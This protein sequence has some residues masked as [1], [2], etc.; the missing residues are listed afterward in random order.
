MNEGDIMDRFKG[1]RASI[2][3]FLEK[4]S[5]KDKS[6]TYEYYED[7]LL[8]LENGK[9]KELGKFDELYPKYEDKMELT[10]CANKLIMP[11][12]IDTHIHY[13][14]TDIIGSYGEKLLEW[15]RKYTFPTEMKFADK[16]IAKE[17]AD[18]FINELSKNC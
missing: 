13:A 16:K 18:F 4:L 6:H 2:L 8:I 5:S 14:Q 17:T 9:V 11:G 3:H 12:F 10:L 7:G 15:L 1:F